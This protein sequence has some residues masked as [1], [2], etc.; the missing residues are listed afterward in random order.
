MVSSN[1]ENI[2]EINAMGESTVT[3]KGQT[4]IPADVREAMGIAAGDRIRF[5]VV[6]GVARMVRVGSVKDIKG[7]LRRPGL[8]EVTLEDMDSAV[9]DGAV[10]RLD[11]SR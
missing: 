11:R 3:I 9:A 7:M 6:D 5:V 2:R 8:P 1:Q 10:E 4:T